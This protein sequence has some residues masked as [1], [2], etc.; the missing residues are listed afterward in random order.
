MQFLLRAEL[1]RPILFWAINDKK[2]KHDIIKRHVFHEGDKGEYKLEQGRILQW[3]LG[4]S[5]D[6]IVLDSSGN[7]LRI[8]QESC[9]LLETW[10][11]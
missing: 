5:H 2:S 7:I 9:E 8:N 4:K 6:L 1:E 3:N 10:P 11:L